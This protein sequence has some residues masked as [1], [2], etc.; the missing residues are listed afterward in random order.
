[1]SFPNLERLAQVVKDLRD[2]ETGCPWDL[3]QTHQSLLRYLIEE[4][5]EFHHAVE[6]NNYKD[7]EEE[8]GDVLLQVVLHSQL[9][10]EK[11]K[12]DLDSV[13]KVIADK[14]IRRHPH[15]F[16]NPQGKVLEESE[17]KDN[18]QKIKHDEKGRPKQ[19]H[20]IDK[21]YLKFPS[22]FAAE[23]IGKKTN[24]INFDWDNAH[25]VADKV[26]EEWQELK[27]ELKEDHKKN[28]IRIKEELGDLLFSVAQ[29]SRHLD[30]EPED[31]LRCANQKF[32]NRFNTMEDLISNDKKS[33]EQMNQEEMEDYWKKVKKIE[34]D[35]L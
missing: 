19:K 8:L 32:I 14:M 29:L 25:Q 13:S 4:S 5:Y 7:M 28:H 1:M 6:L 16:N 26:E 33:L 27:V 35:N 2:P 31:A 15:V 11:K 20:R 21:S 3:K 10:S 23:K 18:W 34:K 9:A 24:K 22:L 17:I 12:F 30:I